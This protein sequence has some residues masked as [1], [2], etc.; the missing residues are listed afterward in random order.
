MKHILTIILCAA[1]CFCYGQER[2]QTESREGWWNDNPSFVVPIREIGVTARRPMKEI[3]VQKTRL[4]TL[5]LHENIA[6]SMADVLTFNTSIFVKQYGRATLSTVAFRGTSPSHRRAR[7]TRHRATCRR[8]LQRPV[9]AGHRLV[10]HVRRVPAP[11]LRRRPL[12][13]FDA[14]GLFLVAERFQ[15]QK[16]QQETERLR[17]RSQYRRFLLSRRTQQERR[18]PRSAPVAG[19][20]LQ[21]RRRQPFRIAGVVRPFVA[22]RPDAVGRPQGGRRLLQRAARA[23][24]ARHLAV[25]S[26]PRELEGRSQGGVYPYVDGLRFREVARQRQHGA[27]DPLAQPDRYVFRPGRGR[28]FR[29]RQVA[30]YGRPFGAPASGRKRRQER[31]ADERSAAA[32]RQPQEGA[33]RLRSGARRAV[34]LRFGQVPADGPA[35]AVA[36]AARGD[37]RRRLDAGHPRL[38][39]RLRAFAPR[40][41]GGQ[42]LR[43]A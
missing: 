9:C 27:D 28:I 30:L 26:S 10:Q 18:L 5:V 7:Q 2:R 12:A 14:R 41:G 29:R 31:P 34:G 25:G 38:L 40:Q 13:E 8:G 23:D 16:L 11:D 42:S 37:V 39:R 35:G 22:R 6:L 32:R 20:L 4:D 15:V 19:T 43:V 1:S 24:A 33:G 36:G 3:G 17:R 21:F